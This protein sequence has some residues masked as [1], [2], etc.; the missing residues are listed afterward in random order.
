[1]SGRQSALE[2]ELPTI[3]LNKTFAQRFWYPIGIVV[4]TVAAAG[5]C[6]LIVGGLDRGRHAPFSDG[7][8]YS[9][10]RMM[11]GITVGMAVAGTFSPLRCCVNFAPDIQA[12]A[13]PH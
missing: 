2:S 7:P 10:W 5:A 12:R 3:D 6:W 9:L 8:A 1:M 13:Y 4:L 11:I